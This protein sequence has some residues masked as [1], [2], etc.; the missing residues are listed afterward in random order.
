[1]GNGWKKILLLE[2]CAY[3]K[4]NH[5]EKF[6]DIPIDILKL[7]KI[8]LKRGNKLK[9]RQIL[10]VIDNI[11]ICMEIMKKILKSLLGTDTV[12]ANKQEKKDKHSKT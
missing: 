7:F 11:P 2:I 5:G 6:Q 8:L 12:P 1:M 3:F 10:I 9:K 4:H